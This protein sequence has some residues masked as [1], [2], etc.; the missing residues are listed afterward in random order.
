ML[1]IKELITKVMPLQ[2]IRDT[3]VFIRSESTRK[4]TNHAASWIKYLI[5]EKAFFPAN[6][7][8]NSPH[9]N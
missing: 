1:K 3:F 2:E 8:D 7:L 9:Y 4:K 5:A 6:V